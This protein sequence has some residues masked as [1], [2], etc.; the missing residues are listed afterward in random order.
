MNNK[1]ISKLPLSLSAEQNCKH[2][3]IENQ[4]IFFVLLLDFLYLCTILRMQR[5]TYK[6]L[7]ENVIKHQGDR[8][9]YIILD[10]RIT[11]R[12]GISEK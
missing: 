3:V 7:Q 2:H 11:E 10:L 6:L 8:P 1:N 4:K 5:Y 12:I 9:A